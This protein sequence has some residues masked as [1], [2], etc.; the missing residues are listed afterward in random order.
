MDATPR[1]ATC[2]RGGRDEHAST[3]EEIRS[4][5]LEVAVDERGVDL[6]YFE[7]GGGFLFPLAAP[8]TEKSILGRIKETPTRPKMFVYSLQQ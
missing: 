4:H 6:H 5:V 1:Y 7:N 8:A 2:K 3:G